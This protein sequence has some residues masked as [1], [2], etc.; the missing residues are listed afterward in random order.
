MPLPALPQKM[1]S[2]LSEKSIEQTAESAK[3]IKKRT[4][5]AKNKIAKVESVTI[6]THPKLGLNILATKA[7]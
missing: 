1:G 2:L 3:T 7:Y 5:P 6:E 4:T